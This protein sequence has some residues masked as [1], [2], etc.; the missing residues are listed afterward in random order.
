M[1]STPGLVINEEVKSVGKLL[2]IDEVIALINGANEQQGTENKTHYK[3]GN[4]I[5]IHMGVIDE[6][7]FKKKFKTLGIL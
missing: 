6:I 4:L 5:E 7:A 2:S 3:D 1:T